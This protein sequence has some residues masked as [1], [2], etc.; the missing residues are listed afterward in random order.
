MTN[1]Q[2]TH[3]VLFSGG[4]SSA[5]V[6]EYVKKKYGKD[7]VI[8]F[9][10]ETYWE[11]PDNYRFMEDVAE[12]LG[13]P[14]TTRS[15][16]R[17]PE[18]IFF[19]TGYLGNS[20]LARCS[21]ELKVKQTIVFVEEMLNKGLKPILYFG[22]GP[23]E[24]HRA[25]SLRGH[26]NHIGVEGVETRFPLIET[27]LKETNVRDRVKNLWKIQ[28]PRMYGLNFSHAN[29]GGRCVRGGFE[30]YALLF[31]TWPNQYKLQEEMEERFRDKFKKNVSILK[32]NGGPYTLKELRERFINDP[33]YLNKLLSKKGLG[34][35]GED[36]QG[37][38]CVCTID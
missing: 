10:T 5:V 23:H 13:L 36:M 12:Y 7:N 35:E 28:L 17:T 16:G 8:L 22:I 2:E 11:D 14:I 21:E 26:Y 37:A 6:A 27:D 4:A 25:E 32:K 29:C 38:P 1:L 30:H 9:F 15:D 18:E 34:E 31:V 20:R 33:A 19:D 3:V 24:Q